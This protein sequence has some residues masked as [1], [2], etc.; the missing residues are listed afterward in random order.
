M[1]TGLPQD[2][3]PQ[4]LVVDDDP[5]NLEIL[6]EHLSALRAR[7]VTAQS[8][9]AAWLQLLRHGSEFD[10]VLLDRMMP[11]PDGM[12]IL[13][14]IKHSP[15]A[16][17]LPVVMQTGAA[18][19]DQVAEG[20]QAGAYY[21]LTKP[22]NHEALLAIVRAA[23]YARQEQLALAQR[24]ERHDDALRLALEGRFAFR[25]ITD[26]RALAHTV[27]HLAEAPEMAAIGLMELMT[28]AIEHGNLGI[29]YAQK[30][31]LIAA[32]TWYGE[33]DRRLA[34]PE[35]AQLRGILSFQVGAGTVRFEIA[36]QGPGFD[37]LP[38]LQLDPG[39]AFDPNGR[40]IAMARMLSFAELEYLG[41]GNRVAAT[42]RAARP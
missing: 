18:T 3:L 20:L 8:G 16:R 39:R 12:E 35:N 42:V 33:L 10:L 14:R 1:N 17:S 7:I 32:G 2:F 31:E 23:L 40:G 24:V 4:I 34:L 22:F 21:Y 9:E 38:Y 41:P 5:V 37:W 6:C 13:R 28:N 25:S 30:S 15:L 27:S 11:A 26:A 19:P 36:D 29:S